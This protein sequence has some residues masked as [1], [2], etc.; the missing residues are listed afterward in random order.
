MGLV[1]LL[2]IILLS[3]FQSVF[4]IGL[5]LIGTPT[6][7][8]LGYN[9]FDVLNILIPFSIT[10]SLL[11]IIYSKETNLGFSK[12]MIIYC[13]PAL[14]LALYILI[15]NENNINIILL[16]SLTIVFFSL[17][18]LSK[19]KDVVFNRD[20]D[21]KINISLILL[22]IIHGFTNLGGSLLTLISAN[23]SNNKDLMRYNIA[24]GYLI[25]GIVQL[26]FI[27]TFYNTLVPSN[28]Y[29]LYIHIISFFLAQ[30]FYKR[31]NS[32]MFSRVLNIIVLIYGS[33]IFINNL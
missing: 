5:L 12:K 4:G 33:Y 9:F 31:I 13:I 17:V 7:L 22:G 2:I 16:T 21:R 26:L 10:I 27:N 25:L 20:S 3:I 30:Y 18:N 24:S 29:Y 1:E 23:I 14:I 28:L 15:K 11:Q 19:F 6:F 8:L 32:Q